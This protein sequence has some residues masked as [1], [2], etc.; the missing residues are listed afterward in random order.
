MPEMKKKRVD[1]VLKD[2]DAEAFEL[3]KEQL[4]K[5]F[6]FEVNNIA[7]HKWLMKQVQ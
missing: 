7:A 2:A 1:I 3:L 5:R 6:G 4:A